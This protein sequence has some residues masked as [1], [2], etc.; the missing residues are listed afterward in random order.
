MSVVRDPG[1]WIGLKSDINKRVWK[2]SCEISAYSEW[3]LSAARALTRVRIQPME[4]VKTLCWHLV[5]PT[6]I[7]YIF[8][9]FWGWHQLL[10]QTD[11]MGRFELFLSPQLFNQILI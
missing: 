11:N 2:V 9:I 6:F 3:L 7:F 4:E 10:G 8:Y 5:Q 1:F